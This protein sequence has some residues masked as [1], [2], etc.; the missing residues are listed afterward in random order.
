VRQS[1]RPDERLK[2]G[3]PRWVAIEQQQHGADFDGL[4]FPA[5]HS[6]LPARRLDVQ[7]NDATLAVDDGPHHIIHRKHEPLGK[8]PWARVIVYNLVTVGVTGGIALFMSSAALDLRS[9]V[10]FLLAPPAMWARVVVLRTVDLRFRGTLPLQGFAG[11]G[12]RAALWTEV[13]DKIGPALETSRVCDAPLLEAARH[14]Y[15]AWRGTE[16]RRQKLSMRAI[17]ARV[18]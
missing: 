13:I 5:E 4:P 8:L 9:P 11:V 16:L 17:V 7:H 18:P 12:R 3:P 2:F 10:W 6:P 14:S 1:L 15:E